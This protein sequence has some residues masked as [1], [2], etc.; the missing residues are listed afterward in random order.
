MFHIA[1]DFGTF[2]S[3]GPEA[4]QAMKAG[5]RM[6]PPKNMEKQH[7]QTFPGSERLYYILYL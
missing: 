6:F 5:E 3:S 4:L 2:G 7:V 1:V